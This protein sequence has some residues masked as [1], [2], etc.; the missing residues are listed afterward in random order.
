MTEDKK[1]KPS[2][3]I[4][5]LWKQEKDGKEYFAGEVEVI[6][7]NPTKIAIFPNDKKEEGSNQPDFNIVLSEPQKKE[8]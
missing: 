2:K 6:A 1:K 7:G 8:D 4:G 3:R 5:A